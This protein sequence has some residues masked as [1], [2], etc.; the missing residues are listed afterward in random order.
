MV[1]AL[2][3]SPI[4]IYH[5]GVRLLLVKATVPQ[6]RNNT[7]SESGL[8]YRLSGK[9]Y[10]QDLYQSPRVLRYIPLLRGFG[11][12][13]GSHVPPDLLLNSF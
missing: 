8:G 5:R 9:K 11:L 6:A 12:S 4:I 1:A 10:L 13:G 2:C 7:G 3:Y